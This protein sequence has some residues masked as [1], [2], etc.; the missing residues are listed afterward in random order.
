MVTSWRW[1]PTRWAR[2][3][4][5]RAKLLIF[6]IN[7]RL[8]K[9]LGFIYSQQLQHCVLSLK[10]Q[11]VHNEPY[12]CKI[13]TSRFGSSGISTLARTHHSNFTNNSIDHTIKFER[14]ILDINFSSIWLAYFIILSIV[15][16][17]KIL[18]RN[19]NIETIFIEPIISLIWWNVKFNTKYTSK[20]ILYFL[21]CYLNDWR[22]NLWYVSVL[23]TVIVGAGS[24]LMGPLARQHGVGR[25]TTI[26][27]EPLPLLNMNDEWNGGTAGMI[28]IS[29]ESLNKNN[30]RWFWLK[31]KLQI[32]QPGHRLRLHPTHVIG[33]IPTAYY[34]LSYYKY[35]QLLSW[36]YILF[37][38][39]IIL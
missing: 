3:K 27:P 8:T 25:K 35:N 1:R 32:L 39:V 2:L 26:P 33:P 21:F 6:G 34:W 29:S 13:S 12:W 16:F 23:Q 31:F 30:E 24:T 7:L 17:L 10:V 14:F 5:W 9:S 19:E 15:W 11:R 22:V 4:R 28:I 36:I 20:N 18:R 38:S 37:L